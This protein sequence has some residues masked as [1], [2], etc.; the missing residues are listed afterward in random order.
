MITQQLTTIHTNPTTRKM[1]IDNIIRY[2][3]NK[4]P[5][6]EHEIHRKFIETQTEIGWRHLSRGRIS[7]DII[8][9]IHQDI[10]KKNS[11]PIK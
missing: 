10:K 8:D 1:L 11:H 6:I 9:I 3:E 7:K 2:Y 4:P 5:I